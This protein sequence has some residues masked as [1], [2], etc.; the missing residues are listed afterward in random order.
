MLSAM[1]HTVTAVERAFQLAKS[2][3]C[4]SLAEIKDRLRAEGYSAKQITGRAMSTQLGALIK[5]ARATS[6]PT[7]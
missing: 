2:G 5:A 3:D 4:A 6:A 7:T 1:D